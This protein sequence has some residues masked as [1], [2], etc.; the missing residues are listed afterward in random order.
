MVKGNSTIYDVAE[1]AGVSIA[2]VSR[3]INNPSRVSAASKKKVHEAMKKLDFEPKAEAVARARRNFKRIGVI[4]PFLTSPSFVQRIRG[5][6]NALASTEYELIIYSI[7]TSEQLLDYYKS[8]PVTKKIDG[9]IILALPIS[10]ESVQRFTEH[11]IPVVLVEIEHPGLSG[12]QINNKVGGAMAASYLVEKGYR[13]LGFIGEKGQPA[14]S[15]HA[16]DQRFIGFREELSKRGVPLNEKNIIFHY[17][18]IRKTTAAV[19][20]VIKN[21]EYPVAFFAASDL[22]A[23]SVIKAAR[24]LNLKIPQELAVI[25][26]DD[27]DLADYMDITTISQSLDESGRAAVRLLFERMKQPESVPI[28]V[29][30]DLRIIERLTT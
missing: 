26:F 27:I 15:L 19:K 28:N 3:V 21:A 12:I 25:G 6:T 13:N 5:I 7:E 29:V 23:V 17:P 4:T 2:T 22:E 9:L 8:L 16:T 11:G 24:E 18:G 14:Y 20:D 10:K 30:L 1:L